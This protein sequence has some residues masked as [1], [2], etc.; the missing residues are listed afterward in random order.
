MS[1]KST[2]TNLKLEFLNSRLDNVRMSQTE[3]IK[4]KAQ[5]ARAE[6]VVDLAFAIGQGARRLL[7]KRVLRPFRRMTASF[8]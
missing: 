4:A 3:R 1:V 7:N 2:K 8:G 6:A 5:L